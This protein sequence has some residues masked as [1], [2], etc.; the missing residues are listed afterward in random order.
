MRT[1]P[2]IVLALA[3][4]LLTGCA[5]RGEPRCDEVRE[6]QSA[7]SITPLSVPADLAGLERPGQL[8]IPDVPPSPA[9]TPLPGCL[10]RPPD[11][12]VAR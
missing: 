2:A 12:I 10:D 4:L 6:Y 1:T 9:G 11:F 3:G 7:G 5:S 8:V